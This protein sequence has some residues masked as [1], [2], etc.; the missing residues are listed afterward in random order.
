MEMKLCERALTCMH[1]SKSLGSLQKSTHRILI[2]QPGTNSG[3]RKLIPV[4]PKN[5]TN[6]AFDREYFKIRNV[7]I[8]GAKL[9][10]HEPFCLRILTSH[11]FF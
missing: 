8:A 11:N 1:L 10:V 7:S 5:V 3:Q 4:Q 2:D 9:L 6:M